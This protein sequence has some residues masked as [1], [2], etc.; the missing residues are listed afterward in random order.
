[1]IPFGYG[2]RPSAAGSR[3]WVVDKVLARGRAGKLR[4]RGCALASV[5]LLSL[6]V[7]S[8]VA[9]AQPAG[10][11]VVAG[12]AQI[13]AQISASG[14][15]TLINQSSSKAI[16]NWQSFSVGQGG[17]VQFNQPSSSAITLNR[18]TG[19]GASSIDGAIRAN[20]QVWL[21]NPN[22]L[23]FGNGA[24]INVGGL[25]ATTSDIADQDFLAGRYNF[26]STGG[27]G[28]ITN[29][30]TITA[31]SGGSVVLSSPSVTN[32]GLIQAQA[33]HVVLGGTDTFTVDFSGDH[34]LSYAVGANSG[35]G[36]V[37][38]SGKLSAP[39]GTILLTARAAAGVQD[40]VINNS[41]MV[42]ATSV[43]QEN[44]EIILEADNGTVSNSGTLD[45]SG[46]ATGES[47]G[48]VKVLGQQVQVADGAKIDV[49]GDG[50][51]GSALIG[52]NLHGAGPEP[53][54]QTT[55]VGK[56]IINASAITS[57]KGGTVAITST[58]TTT[59]S[60]RISAKGGIVSGQGGVVETSGHVLDFAGSSVNAGVGGSWLLDPYDLTVDSTAAAII[61]STLG[62][63]TNVT[64]KTTAIGTAGPG[65]P[66]PSG[67]GDIFINAP[68]SWNT[69]AALT[70][71]AYHAIHVDAPITITG[72]GVLNLYVNDGGSGG[73]YSFAA[74]SSVN[75]GPTNNSGTLNIGTSG[76]ASA[77]SFTLL[78]CMTAA[79]CANNVQNINANLGGN[80]ALATPLDAT[81]VSGWV[82]IGTDG[83]GNVQNAGNGFTG[84]F[85]GLGN[86]ISNFAMSQPLGIYVAPFGYSSGTIR[87][88]GTVGVNINGAS[89]VSGLLG[90]NALGGI[91]SNA[92][93]TGT[94]NGSD[95][96]LYVGGLVAVNH[97][98]ITNAYTTGTVSGNSQAVG[99]L[100]GINVGTI[101]NAFSTDAVSGGSDV[102][103]LVGQNNAGTITNAYATGAVGSTTDAGGL[104]G[105]Y[106]AAGNISN[107]YATGVVTGSTVGGLIGSN[108]SSTPVTNGY[109][110]TDTTATDTSGSGAIGKTTSQ[111][112][113]ALPA[114]FSASVWSRGNGNSQVT[115][116]M[117][118]NQ[119]GFVFV[120]SDSLDTYTLVFTASQ[121]QAINNNLNGH[122]GLGALLDASA[123][124]NWVPLGV[125]ASGVVQNGGQGFAG[126]F[127]GL[128][129]I[130]NNL[131]VSVSTAYAGLFGYNSGTIKSLGVVGGSVTGN[132]GTTY[133]GGLAAYNTGTL[134]GVV[135]TSAVNIGTSSGGWAGGLA[136]YSTTGN[137]IGSA[138]LGS[139]TGGTNGF[140][141]GL[142]G[143]I[144]GGI[145]GDVYATGAVLGGTGT[146]AGG[147]VGLISGGTI[148]DA[149]STGAV[150]AG[151]GSGGGLIGQNTGS[152]G[153]VT[154]TYW[155]MD[156][157]GLTTD[158]SP[159]GSTGL[160]TA[161]LQGALPAGFSGTV[162]GTG[163]NLYP[164]FLYLGTPQIITGKVTDVLGNPVGSSAATGIVTVSS[165]VNAMGS[166]SATAGAN[167]VYY[168]ELPP[169]TF[170]G[171]NQLMTYV[172]NSVS[173]SG[174]VANN[175]FQNITA[176]QFNMNLTNTRLE[177]VTPASSLSGAIAGLTMAQGSAPNTDLLY[178]AGFPTGIE[179]FVQSS[180]ATGFSIDMPVNVSTT[181]GTVAVFAT[182]PI[183]QTS[184][185]AITANSL[186]GVTSGANADITLNDNGN[187]V[188]GAGF[189]TSSGNASLTNPGQA[190]TTFITNT[191]VNGNLTVIA[192][193]SI[194]RVGETGLNSATGLV[195]L[196]A[197]SDISQGAFALTAGGGLTASAGGSLTLDNGGNQVGGIASL[198]APNGAIT[199]TNSINTTLGNVSA[200]NL[201]TIT[202]GGSL[203]LAPGTTLLSSGESIFLSAATS[204]LENNTATIS[205]PTPGH[206]FLVSAGG[207]VTLSAAANAISGSISIQAPGNI[208][209][210][211]NLNTLISS[212]NNGVLADDV[213][214]AAA[215]S[216]TVNVL[217][218]G[219]NLNDLGGVGI[220]AVSI[221]LTTAGGTIG[222]FPALG[223]SGGPDGSGNPDAAPVSL[224]INSNGG[225]VWLNSYSP[226]SIANSGISL[227]GGFLA[228]SGY[229]SVAV[230]APIT[231]TG[232][233]IAIDA[234][235]SIQVNAPITASTGSAP[236][237][238]GLNANDPTLNQFSS[239]NLASN[240][241]INGITGS[242]LLTASVIN[243][244][245]SGG[246]DGLSGSIGTAAQPL[247]VTSDTGQL[248][249]AIHTWDGNA[250]VNSAVRVSLDNNN[251][252][253]SPLESLGLGIFLAEGA[254]AMGINT[255]GSDGFFGQVSLA[256]AGPIT[257]TF[258]VVSGNLT[259]TS[260]GAGAGINLADSGG[261]LDPGNQ[262]FGTLNLN[263]S[264][265]ATFYNGL[266]EGAPTTLNVG[267]STV[268]GAL[269]L[270]SP[271]A[272]LKVNDPAGGT[273]H[274]GSIFVQAGAASDI[275][276][277]SPL[278]SDTS[279]FMSAGVSI[280]QNTST[281][282]DA[283]IQAGTTLFAEA[284]G[285]SLTLAD[286]GNGAGDP[287]NHIAGQVVVQSNA[288]NVVFANVP[289]ITFGIDT[290]DSPSSPN[291]LA[292]GSFVAITPGNITFAPGASISAG[293]S[294][295]AG[296][297][298][299]SLEAG[300]N[301][302]NNSGLGASTVLMGSTTYFQIYSQNPA[303]DVF[304]G[305]NSGNTA[306]WDTSSGA[307]VTAAAS[308]Y[309]FA[310][311]PTLTVTI[312]KVGKT[313]GTDDS[314]ALQSLASTPT[315]LEPG[316]A[317]A[318][319]GDTAASVF[320][321]TPAVTSVGTA[322][323]AGV[324]TYPIIASLG[325]GD[326]YAITAGG[327][328]TV[329]PA[330]LFYNAASVS[331]TYG[332]VNPAFSG[333][334]T[335]FVNSDTQGSAT[336]GTL[337]FASTAT[338]TSPAGSYDI[339]GS[340]LNAANYTFVQAPGNATALTITV[341][342]APPPIALQSFTSSIQPPP[343]Q[344]P[345]STPLGATQ[346]NLI[347]LPVVP[348]PPPAP[349]PPGPPPVLSLLTDLTDTPIAS[350]Q[351]TSDV[352]AS[353]DGGNFGGIS[354]GN[355]G[356]SPGDNFGVNSGDNSGDNSGGNT[357]SGD[358]GGGVI[359][360]KM[361]TNAPP[362]PG[363][364]PTDPSALSSFGNA[365]LWQ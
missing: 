174:V 235:G 298:S 71:D 47:G 11:S 102:G 30:G 283:H 248:S 233:I 64:L 107:V 24:T 43:R 296:G 329:T 249:L 17:S 211:N 315:G 271:A 100:V 209:L 111:L 141:G 207:D 112:S 103:G 2:Q 195:T 83:A 346:L 55:T 308:R 186:I 292:A 228:L 254:A 18:V 104:V 258:G 275:F 110:D 92:Y 68:I 259:L 99:G 327:T 16:I 20:G 272:A 354:G 301:F 256:A 224:S 265:N 311:Q 119:A 218:A 305:L 135:A 151:A 336:T 160:H 284:F 321:G 197:G 78:Y 5:S 192:P 73:D 198:A 317:G 199:F 94:V 216:V 285:G 240:S 53:N 105:L 348:P 14:A 360:P 158:N 177:M 15:T 355:S 9:S 323:S 41:G 351:T 165:L 180:N 234:G 127:D 153:N 341:P 364:P 339:D 54:A 128:G 204:I 67:S 179:L 287:G 172:N 208:G 25:L 184:G 175:Y 353:L 143:Q 303:N 230:N 37:A 352:A 294:A 359:I 123:A 150:I 246:Q 247:Q 87:D 149:F 91:V 324:G 124:S 181:S 266:G 121:L 176:S 205:Q 157:S 118:V 106:F 84:N 79:V 182:G 322:A 358:T 255:A 86:T 282:T 316:V 145:I 274:A 219:H 10:G 289:G 59:V 63:S 220:T 267:T 260:T 290:S 136:G 28:S 8:G 273:V 61:D 261:F 33:G 306:V 39:G 264:G 304:G 347:A 82:S 19:T 225:N 350:D 85:E 253:F 81:G 95:A 194:I 312:G 178:D 22:G 134:N 38:N 147:L 74:G 252:A 210:T 140:A 250:Y 236:G 357:S 108:S 288:A 126:T 188:V 132:A 148:A 221:S 340:G 171:T 58:G 245:A 42:Q 262:V 93:S 77:A 113:S 365:S 163:A 291:N 232:N 72:A 343:P 213:S 333:T 51:G 89:I 183:T 161:A 227:G 76:P 34:L 32:K 4:V 142:A 190:F 251:S 116:Y 144:N 314:A 269:M 268:S 57:G 238:I 300:G 66:N 206:L 7:M 191:S 214:T 331:R 193:N 164:E 155:D 65:N 295:P 52:G 363:P 212:I 293:T 156:T 229:S 35:G 338:T 173:S 345:A 356:G 21:L 98:T 131:T 90:S 297:V 60:A 318:F 286:L 45:A 125:N 325:V 243:L 96:N 310:L 1:M 231:T 48:T 122:Y 203:T 257:E 27:K 337:V 334:V 114:G 185:S 361:L 276:I 129:N 80:Y 44:G 281:T 280:T 26:S 152:A 344:D 6:A 40:A 279:I 237:V 49:S 166:I 270:F 167:G 307:S 133:A 263:S 239:L 222:T 159:T 278:V 326:G 69:N 46:K 56:A 189:T 13:S 138:A 342:T 3:G 241:D 146:H 196:S 244:N 309:V 226:V 70:L 223:I 201:I 202:S 23:L 302:I 88:V 117:P 215:T 115:P 168:L 29:S 277:S 101:T 97:G 169:G 162:W 170:T 362:P 349:P 217:G 332:S 328:L 330:T 31:G 320:S 200:A 313:Y 12:Q 109:W 120:G 187:D 36:K 62:A 75:Y 137:I 139:V 319:Q 154:N 50:G 130:I 299:V 242:G 335:G